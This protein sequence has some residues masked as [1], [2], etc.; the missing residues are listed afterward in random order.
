M[1]L[2]RYHQGRLNRLVEDIKIDMTDLCSYCGTEPPEEVILHVVTR[3]GVFTTYL[4]GVCV[5][6]LAESD[7]GDRTL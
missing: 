4:S 5:I 1:K 6:C 3:K 7:K 2:K